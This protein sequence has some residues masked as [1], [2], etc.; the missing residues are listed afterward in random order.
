[1]SNTTGKNNFNLLRFA[2]ASLVIFSHSYPI[3]TGSESH[4]PLMMLSHGQLTLGTLAVSSFFI[5]SGYLIA[6][7][8]TKKPVAASYLN[9]RVRRIYPGF[10]VAAAV[11]AFIVTPLFSET[12]FRQVITPQFAQDFVLK[13]L[14]L[15]FLQP[16]AGFVGN[17][18][19]GPVNGSLWSIPFEFWC[20]IGLMAVG[21][22]G[23]LKR[24]NW[25]LVGLL[26]LVVLNFVVQRYNLKISGKV[27]GRIFGY[28]TMWA[29]VLPYFVAGM[30][31]FAFGNRIKYRASLA[32]VAAVFM[33]I[34]CAVPYGMIFVLPFAAAY[35]ILWLAFI[36]NQRAADFARNGDYSFGI[37]LYA[38][39]ISQT[40]AHFTGPTSPFLIFAIA[41]PASVALGA[42]SWHLV[43]HRFMRKNRFSTAPAT[44]L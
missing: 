12:S 6:Q 1:M 22:A 7:S 40:I 37:Y 15:S 25:L 10:L 28:P 3:A 35:I 19:A 44:A 26:L 39:P 41:W 5:I 21:L 33:L 43:E 31:F 17:P 29:Q 4:E 23:L 32:A 8:W 2:F 27:F 42:L 9:K 20:Y 16:A 13:A 24:P 34:G 14:Q 30:T 11:S 38:F 18:A 36:P